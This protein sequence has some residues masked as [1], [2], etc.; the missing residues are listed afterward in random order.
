MAREMFY[1]ATLAYKT[2]DFPKAAAKFKEGLEL[3]KAV[4]ND[5]PNY[6]DDDLNK[7]DTGLIVKRYLRA[8]RQLQ[9]PVPADMP[10]KD[11][12][13]LVQNDNTVD[14]FDAT[15]MIGV[16]QRKQP[17]GAFGSEAEPGWPRS[18]PPPASP[19]SKK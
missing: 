18:Q 13:P 8:L 5:F 2:G 7:K 3:W 1:E 15:E 17:A 14:P 12:L 11:Y 16:V 10:F 6:R 19:D 4:M 9:M